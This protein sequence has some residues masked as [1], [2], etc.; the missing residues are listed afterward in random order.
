MVVPIILDDIA[1]WWKKKK[2]SENL[3]DYLNITRDELKVVAQKYCDRLRELKCDMEWWCGGKT[4]TEQG[5]LELGSEPQYGSSKQKVVEA[6]GF[7]YAKVLK[8]AKDTLARNQKIT[9]DILEPPEGVKK[10]ELREAMKSG[11][12]LDKEILKQAPKEHLSK[13]GD[14]MRAQLGRARDAIPKDTALWTVA[15]LKQHG[16]NDVTLD[17]WFSAEHLRMRIVNAESAKVAKEA[18]KMVEKGR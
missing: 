2:E 7:D 18:L 13:I 4:R 11:A 6:F 14:W 8:L 10:E 17:E 12:P 16:K 9:A 1:E 15:M 3:R 5:L